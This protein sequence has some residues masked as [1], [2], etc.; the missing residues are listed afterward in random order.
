MVIY[1]F[2]KNYNIYISNGGEMRCD[3]MIF[4][5]IILFYFFFLSFVNA[6]MDG[7]G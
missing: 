1:V 2:Y 3:E 6:K 7:M 4:Y 5:F